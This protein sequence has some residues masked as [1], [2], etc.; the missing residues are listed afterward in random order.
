MS[1]PVIF[2]IFLFI[3]YGAGTYYFLYFLFT[4]LEFYLTPYQLRPRM[5]EYAVL[6][7]GGFVSHGFGILGTAMMLILFFYS[8]R[9]RIKLFQ[10]W[11]NLSYFL[12][13]HIF[14]GIFGPLFIILHSTFKLN[15]IV[16]VSFWSMVAVAIS[17]IWG[18]FLYLQIPRNRQGIELNRNEIESRQ[19]NYIEQ[20]RSDFDL[21]YD[22]VKTLKNII[23]ENS[24]T[25]TRAFFGFS[26][27]RKNL[28]I[29]IHN[30]VKENNI[31]Y[32]RMKELYSLVEKYAKLKRQSELMDVFQKY[33]HYWHVFHKPFAYLMIIIMA[34]HIAVV[35]LMGYRW[36]F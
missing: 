10:G 8:A 27:I 29:N 18:R 7:P 1:R 4:G 24:S 25:N 19:E 15:G 16:S 20:L 5:Q 35:I 21:E 12:D 2:K 36:I 33:F 11:G 3:I 14:L 22:S 30:F 26:K 23:V 13:I 9:K 32:G 28:K 6:K 17:G 34:V 31:P